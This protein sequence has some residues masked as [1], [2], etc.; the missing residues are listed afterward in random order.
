MTALEFLTQAAEQT[1]VRF[2]HVI[3]DNRSV[4]VG[5]EQLLAGLFKLPRYGFGRWILIHQHIANA[6]HTSSWVPSHGKSRLWAPAVS[7]LGSHLHWRALNGAA[8]AEASSAL[9]RFQKHLGTPRIF[10]ESLFRTRWA[11]FHLERLRLSAHRY[12]SS[13]P[14]SSFRRS[15]DH[16]TS[17]TAF[18]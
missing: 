17:D 16:L 6:R 11:S 14:R 1:D 12:I 15:V 13:V 9:V 4:Q 10:R 7:G 5:F 8:D 2:M 18:R 3:I